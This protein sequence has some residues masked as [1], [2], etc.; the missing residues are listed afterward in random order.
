VIL[1]RI[2][3]QERKLQF[4]IVEDEPAAGRK[5]AKP[6]SKKAKK[7]R[8]AAKHKGAAPPSTKRKRQ[9]DKRGRRR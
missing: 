4:S 8:S 9:F 6:I 2:L 1:D 5:P 3:A 7:A